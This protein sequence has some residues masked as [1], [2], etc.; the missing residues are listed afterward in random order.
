VRV[1]HVGAGLDT[2]VAALEDRLSLH[3]VHAAT[4]KNA[5]ETINI[6][7]I[8]LQKLNNLLEDVP[9]ATS[10]DVLWIQR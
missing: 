10:E 8:G 5:S 7:H 4:S 1:V 2:G 6:S 9:N 3:Q